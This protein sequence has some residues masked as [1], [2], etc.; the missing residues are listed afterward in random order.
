M[1]VESFT[2]GIQNLIFSTVYYILFIYRITFALVD[3]YHCVSMYVLTILLYFIGLDV[4]IQLR[5]I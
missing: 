1:Y 5:Y 4:I 3:I 2:K